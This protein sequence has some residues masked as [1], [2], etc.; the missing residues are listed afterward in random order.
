MNDIYRIIDAN[1][2]RSSEGLRVIEDISRFHFEKKA[3]TETLREIRHTARKMFTDMSDRLIF[4]RAADKDIGKIISE[5][6]TLDNKTD[7]K[8]LIASNFKRIE[9]GF[10]TIEENLKIV[11]EYERSKKIESLR[12]KI[13][14]IEKNFQQMMKR[15]LPHGLYGITA[16]KYSNG[17]NTIDVVKAM[18]KGGI[19]VIQ[20]REKHEENS[21]RK[22]YNECMEIRK[23]TADHDVLFIV[24][25]YIELA[26][27]ADAD[28]VHAGQDDIPIKEVRKLVGNKIIGGSTHS[29]EQAQA[30]VADGADYIG[31]G[32]IFKTSTKKDVCDPVGLEYLEYA[33]ENID[34]PFVAIGGIKEHN[35]H[36]VVKRGA[37]TICLVTDIVGADNIENK[38]ISLNQIISGVNE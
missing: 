1:L 28:G 31:V 6:T 3:V 17:R 14:T 29:P 38:I 2:N 37:K 34:I 26:M 9:E 7:L 19:K 5:E 12:F 16:E 20:Y 4:A 8:E 32:P 25:D 27:L 22:M 35:I 23:I 33:V 10:R 24:N 11:N 21:F 15:P 13:Y 36:K 18:V 30:V